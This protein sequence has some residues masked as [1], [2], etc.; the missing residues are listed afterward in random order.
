MYISVF[1]VFFLNISKQYRPVNCTLLVQYGCENT[2]FH[3]SIRK[4]IFGDLL[5]GLITLNIQCG[6]IITFDVHQKRGF[7]DVSGNRQQPPKT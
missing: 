4:E 2:A 1:C 7:L 3:I 6:V 5:K